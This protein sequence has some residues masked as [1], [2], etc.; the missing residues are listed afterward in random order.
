MWPYNVERLKVNNDLERMWKKVCLP[1]FIICNGNLEFFFFVISISFYIVNRSSLCNIV[2]SVPT[3]HGGFSCSSV[4]RFF[5]L[6]W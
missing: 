6:M 1:I 3:L 5:F 4:I 2:K